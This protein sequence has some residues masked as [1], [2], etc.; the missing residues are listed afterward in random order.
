MSQPFTLRRRPKE[1]ID[2]VSP[3]PDEHIRPRNRW[4]ERLRGFFGLATLV[5]LTGALLAV[6]LA[7]TLVALA[8]FVATIFN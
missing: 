6:L 7:A 8:V 1:T 3:F 4:Y 5:A 2:I